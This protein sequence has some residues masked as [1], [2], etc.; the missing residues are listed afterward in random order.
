MI[1]Q[2]LASVEEIGRCL[3]QFVKVSQKIAISGALDSAG[4]GSDSHSEAL[5]AELVA[6]AGF[7]EPIRQL[8][9]MTPLGLRRVDLAVPLGGGRLL[10]IEIDG[11]HHD[12][13]S[14]RVIDAV[15][16]ATLRLAG[17][18]VV[19]IRAEDVLHRRA[20]VLTELR[21]LRAL[22]MPA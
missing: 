2:E 10:V 20:A 9:I 18:E 6:E 8:E 22:H 21:R 19:H 3:D 5:A 11:P 15:K 12:E 1:Q 4:A 13:E 14:V 17:H 7:P 16:E